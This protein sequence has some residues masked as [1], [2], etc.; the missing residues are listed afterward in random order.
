ML[1]FLS[2]STDILIKRFFKW[3]KFYFVHINSFSQMHLLLKHVDQLTRGESRN[4]V[5]CIQ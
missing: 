3:Q 1:E 2:Q 5:D 4:S